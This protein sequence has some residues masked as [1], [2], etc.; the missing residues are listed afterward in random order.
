MRIWTKYT[1]KKF[2]YNNV[3]TINT[4]K[5]INKQQLTKHAPHTKS[6]NFCDTKTSLQSKHYNNTI[7]V[8]KLD[9]IGA[10]RYH[11]H[12]IILYKYEVGIDI[13]TPLR[14][15]CLSNSWRTLC[16][17]SKPIT[18]RSSQLSTLQPWSDKKFKQRYVTKSKDPI[19]NQNWHGTYTGKIARLV[20]LVVLQ[21]IL[22][23]KDDTDQGCPVSPYL[24]WL[25]IETMAIISVRQ[26][27]NI[28]GI[29]V[30]A[31]ELKI[32][33]LADD[34]TCFFF[35]FFFMGPV[36]LLIIYLIP[37]I[38]LQNVLVV[39]LIFLNLMLFWLV[40]KRGPNFFPSLIRVLFGN[41]ISL[42]L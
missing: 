39:I 38:G 27:K 32:S 7:G 18:A 8:I 25:I 12:V 15:F 9:L 22:F 14:S 21:L 23:K 1:D 13:L 4:H 37:W 10:D 33:L 11:Y 3:Q 17:H 26:N 36:I 5:Q 30:E 6:L 29:P 24:F 42:K 31:C 34:S 35:F 20:L 2:S 28:K 41:P 40:L 19:D 16:T